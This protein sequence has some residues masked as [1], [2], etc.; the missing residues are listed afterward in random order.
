[1]AKKI[2]H[3]NDTYD[4]LIN[5]IFS[6]SPLQA[7]N[8]LTELLPRYTKRAKTHLY[9][10][11]GIEDTENGKIRLTELQYKTI[12]TDFGDTYVKRAFAELTQYIEYLEKNIDSDATYKAKLRKL[13]SG[14]HNHLLATMDGW[15]FNKCKGFIISD[16]PKI[17]TNPFLIEDINTAREYIRT[18]PKEIRA[19]AMDVQMLL[20][21]FP[22]LTSED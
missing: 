1:M 13:K 2:V 17:N 20:L 9:N 14:T 6:L 8:L 19:T 22:E 18:I 16:R 10:A 7:K 3:G 5:L 15:V 4:M 21:K 11:E 12:R